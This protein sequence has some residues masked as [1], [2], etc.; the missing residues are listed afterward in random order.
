M[1]FR[2]LVRCLQT[3]NETGGLTE[4][5]QQKLRGFLLLVGSIVPYN[6]PD[7]N[8]SQRIHPLKKFVS[9]GVE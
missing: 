9:Q 3:K 7:N 5:F 6:H 1:P 8:N 2:L 4:L